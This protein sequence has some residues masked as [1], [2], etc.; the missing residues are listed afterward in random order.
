ML[1]VIQSYVDLFLPIGKISLFFIFIQKGIS[2]QLSTFITTCDPCAVPL[3]LEIMRPQIG[4]LILFHSIQLP[5]FKTSC[6]FDPCAVYQFSEWPPIRE[7]YLFQCSCLP[8]KQP[9]IPVWWPLPL[10]IWR[11]QIGKLFILFI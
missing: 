9:V 1:H 11:P 3:P 10:K 5:T 6:G 2:I 8:L 7:I 4:K